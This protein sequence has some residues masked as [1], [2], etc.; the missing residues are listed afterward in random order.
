MRTKPQMLPADAVM[1]FTTKG[2]HALDALAATIVDRM[3]DT[4]G[5]IA[6]TLD[7]VSRTPIED[8]AE[9]F[10]QIAIQLEGRRSV[11]SPSA[12]EARSPRADWQA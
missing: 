10:T 11:A 4:P 12:G 2:E 7:M 6:M 3:A 9:A 8:L 5:G 1:W